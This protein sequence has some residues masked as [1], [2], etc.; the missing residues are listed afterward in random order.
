MDSDIGGGSSPLAAVAALVGGALAITG[1][2]G[3]C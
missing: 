3:A 2:D 1:G